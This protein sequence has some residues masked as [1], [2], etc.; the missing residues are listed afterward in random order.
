MNYDIEFRYPNVIDFFGT[1]LFHICHFTE[2]DLLNYKD[3]DN[4]N[5]KN[6]EVSVENL[7]HYLHDTLERYDEK[8]HQDIYESYGWDFNRLESIYTSIH[9][10]AMIITLYNFFEHQ[11]KTLC[12]EVEKLI[13]QDCS[14]YFNKD[15]LKDYRRFL[16]KEA[17]FDFKMINTLWDDMISIKLVRNTLVHSE[18]EIKNEKSNNLKTIKHYCKKKDNIR[19]ISNRI[20]IDKVFVH[21][22]LNEMLK[23]FDLLEKE[24]M[25]FIRRY[26]DKHGRFEVTLPDGA[27]KT[28]FHLA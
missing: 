18:G 26:E 12:L 5:E 9:R 17:N 3:Y 2:I 20:I 8:D 6:L 13:F 11:I 14:S 28:P 23:L 16:K 22:L 7:S 4:Y 15:C 27:S 25:A 21:N 1:T 24:V 19:L 10:K